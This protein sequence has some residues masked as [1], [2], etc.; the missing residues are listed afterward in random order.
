MDSKII[1]FIKL[2]KFSLYLSLIKYAI[3]NPSKGIV[4]MQA[5]KEV[6][7]DRNT[8]IKKQITESLTVNDGLKQLFP[9]IDF[10]VN[11]IKKEVKNIE[12]HLERFFDKLKKNEFPSKEKPYPIDYSLD[13]DFGILLYSLCKIV[14]PE[15][16]VETG[17]AYGRSSTYILESL[18]KNEKGNL[19]S[20]DDT[21]RPWETKE[22]IGSSIPENLKKRWKFFLGTS[23]N[24]LEDIC[25]STN[26]IDIF[27]HDSLH[28]YQNMLYEF[29]LI[30]PYIK[31]NGYLLSDDIMENNA[32]QDFC[33]SKKVKPIIFKQSSNNSFGLIKKV[34][35]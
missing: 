35:N 30:W 12:E 3:T 8:P 7:K 26:G 17:V 5:D 25:K 28:T 29:E 20:I 10:T 14:K 34:S 1:Y 2:S 9:D 27:I 13:S 15:L 11:D 21:F 32:F 18:N 22:K 19:Y 23:K 33:K 6:K 4:M 31:K 24:R 16:I